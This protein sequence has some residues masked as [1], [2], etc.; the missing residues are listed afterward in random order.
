MKTRKIILLTI[1]CLAA[2]IGVAAQKQITGDKYYGEFNAAEDRSSEISHRKITKEEYYKDGKL[3]RT[4]EI[5]DEF[6]EPD[7]RRYVYAEKSGA[8]TEKRELIQI[9]KTYYCRKNNAKWEQSKSWCAGNILR[10][11]SNIVSSEFTV[12]ETKVDNRSATH[13]RQYR[14]YKGSVLAGKEER[15]YYMKQEFWLNGNGLLLRS[16]SEYGL[17]KTSEILSKQADTYEYNPKIKIQ[18]PAITG[19][20]KP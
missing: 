11:I 7:R 14:T 17:V 15:L 3:N 10:G 1:F 2:T 18:A 4:T 6:L 16:E 13:Y 9:G 19:K 12:E 20:T 5:T 8:N